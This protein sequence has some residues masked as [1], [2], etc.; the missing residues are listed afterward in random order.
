MMIHYSKMQ[1]IL[2]FL[3]EAS[4]KQEKTFLLIFKAIISFE[5]IKKISF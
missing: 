5:K 2:V 4:K 1:N 3:Q